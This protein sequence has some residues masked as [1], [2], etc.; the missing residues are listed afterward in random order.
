MSNRAKT[1]AGSW[2][3]PNRSPSLVRRLPSLPGREHH[4]GD[5]EQDRPQRDHQRDQDVRRWSEAAAVVLEPDLLGIVVAGGRGGLLTRCVGDVLRVWCPTDRAW[6]GSS[7]LGE[8]V[9]SCA[10]T[11]GRSRPGWFTMTLQNPP[12]AEAGVGWGP[13]PTAASK[14]AGCSA[15]AWSA[16]RPRRSRC[17]SF[18]RTQADALVAN[19]DVGWGGRSR[20]WRM[21]PLTNP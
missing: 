7:P 10:T 12:Q 18:A 5:Q 9:A 16:T 11:A 13:R 15:A 2:A 1:R 4:P 3:P 8:R 6:T 17:P 21:A 14:R 20:S 19:P